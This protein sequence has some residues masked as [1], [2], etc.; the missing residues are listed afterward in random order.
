MPKYSFSKETLKTIGGV[1]LIAVIVV[2]TFLYGNKQRQEQLRKPNGT[3]TQTTDTS[4]PGTGLVNPSG[5]ATTVPAS[6]A[7][8]QTAPTTTP[9]TGGELA[10]ALPLAVLV[11]LYQYNRHSQRALQS[12]LRN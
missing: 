3:A 11:G 4:K 6:D 2:A 9:E 8:P 10:F 7:Q 1:V 12:S 5:Q